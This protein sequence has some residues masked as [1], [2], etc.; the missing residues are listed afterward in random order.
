[1][2][3]G[4]M[5]AYN[6]RWQRDADAFFTSITAGLTDE[7]LKLYQKLSEKIRDQVIKLEKEL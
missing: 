2:P 4:K 7:E 5:P 3:H 1:M 6:S